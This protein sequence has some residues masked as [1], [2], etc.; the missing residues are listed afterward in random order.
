MKK[1][2]SRPKQSPAL[3]EIRRLSHLVSVGSATL[4][5]FDLLGIGSVEELS[6]CDAHELYERLCDLK[7]MKI[8]P[9][10]EDVFRAAIAQAKNPKLPEEKKNWWYWSR[11]RKER[12]TIEPS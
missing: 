1:K 2:A 8:D 6:R 4:E 10:C 12:N 11:V 9:C 5:D 7:G 3:D